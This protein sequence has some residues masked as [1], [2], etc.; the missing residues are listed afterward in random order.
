MDKFGRPPYFLPMLARVVAFLAALS[1]AVVTAMSTVHA[2]R[3]SLDEAVAGHSDHMI[4]AAETDT[5]CGASLQCSSGDASRCAA[6]CAGLLSFIAPTQGD[7]FVDHFS[8][9]EVL[10]V[11]TAS[12]S[13]TP[14]L[15][16]RP[17]RLR[18]L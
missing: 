14:G 2:A 13:H 9:Q 11:D 10:P 1:F 4:T 6:A 16:E 7:T 12:P 15:N 18:L 5:A 8:T 17:P 3:V